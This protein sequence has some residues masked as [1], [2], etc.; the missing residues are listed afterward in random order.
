MSYDSSSNSCAALAAQVAADNKIKCKNGVLL[1]LFTGDILPKPIIQSP[2]KDISD[3]FE[4]K[5]KDVCYH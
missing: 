5:T 4:P 2:G 3:C 1:S